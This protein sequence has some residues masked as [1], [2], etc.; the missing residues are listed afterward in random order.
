MILSP[1]APDFTLH[2]ERL[3]RAAVL[4]LDTETT[5]LRPFHGDYPFAIVFATDGEQFYYELEGR[6]ALACRPEHAPL[7]DW[8][9]SAPRVFFLHNAK[10]DI[11]M[12]RQNGVEFHPETKFFDTMVAARLVQSDLPSYSLEAAATHFI[13]AKKDDRVKAYIEENGLWDWV[14]H[15]DLGYRIKRMF[16]DRVPRELLQE[17]AEKDAR[18]TYDLGIHLLRELRRL[19]HEA[20]EGWP[21]QEALV[22][23]EMR[24]I[25]I[26]ADMERRGVLVD[27]I[28]CRTALSYEKNRSLQAA[29][30]FRAETGED[31]K[32]SSK[33]FE[34]T[35]PF[36]KATHPRTE[37]GNFSFTGETLENLT[38]AAAR[39]VLDCKDAIARTNFFAGFLYHRDA[40]NR[41]HT[42]FRQAGTKTGRFSSSDMNLQNL[43][44][45]DDDADAEV[46]PIRRAIVPSPGRCF[47]LLDYKAMEYRLMLDYAG[48]IGLIEQVL[49]GVDVHQA[50]ADMLGIPRHHGKTLNFALLYG[51]GKAKLAAMLGL[52][53]EAAQRLKN[54]YFASLPAVRDFIFNV[55]RQARQ[56]G[57]IFNWFGRRSHYTDRNMAYASPNHLIQGGCADIA[58][59]AMLSAADI[60]AQTKSW[61]SLIVH[62]EFVLDM[63]PDDFGVINDI[64]QAMINA[65]PHRYLPMGVSVSHSWR[66]LGDKISG[67]PKSP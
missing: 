20:P 13:G 22:E 2:L 60:L 4:S 25:G 19:D 38:G 15:P 61:M 12:L 46:Y 52:P 30:A 44:R 54:R 33:L 62:D 45:S 17:Y 31:Y 50:T 5:G 6:D 66:S 53:E 51:A 23:Q 27:S 7:R 48:E 58:K 11:H 29:E 41:I 14:E 40:H 59:R 9:R 1:T 57:Y 18:I 28:Y 63:H 8:F 64:L 55:R 24:L 26:V 35:L 43:K 16:F 67:P 3:G 65:Y 39:A 34:R 42:N 47:V 21:K 56:R 49:A 36:D 10:F 32:A 37:H